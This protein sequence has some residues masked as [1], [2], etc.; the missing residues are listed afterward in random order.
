M[1]IKVPDL[2][3]TLDGLAPHISEKTVTFHYEKHHKGYAQKLNDAIKGTPLDGQS[4]EQII[5]ATAK[6]PDGK[7]IFNNAAQVWNHNLF[8]NSMSPKGGGPPARVLA[9]MVDRAFGGLDS[10]HERFID[11]A[12]GRFGSGYVWLTIAAGKLEIQSTANAETPLS[13]SDAAA[14]L[15]C[16]VWEHAYYL[17]YQNER[18]RFV[19]AFLENLVDWNAAENRLAIAPRAALEKIV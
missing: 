19:R 7:A 16:D 10:F 13:R 18:A 8:W 11:C 5:R 9:R 12:R 15:C 4:L 14:L 2:P 17:D 1:P 6:D 3:Y